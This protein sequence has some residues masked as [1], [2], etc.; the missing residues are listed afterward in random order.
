MSGGLD[1]GDIGTLKAQKIVP[2]AVVLDMYTGF[3][4]LLND[5]ERP[6]TPKVK[7]TK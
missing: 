4:T 1:S 2:F 7:Q 3:T 6:T 5:F